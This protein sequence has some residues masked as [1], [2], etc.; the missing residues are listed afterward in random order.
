MKRIFTT[1]II[2]FVVVLA[3]GGIFLYSKDTW[4][5]NDTD[6]I[7]VA[8]AGKSDDKAQKNGITSAIEEA[9]KEVIKS[10]AK[11][12][13]DKAVEQ[14]AG[15]SSSEVREMI[16]SVAE[17]DKDR[18]TDIIVD[19]ITIEDIPDV[20]AYISNK[21][22]DGLKDYAKEKLTEEDYSELTGILE[23]YSDKAIEQINGVKNN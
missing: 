4:F 12:V 7:S 11:K 18:I 22:V 1:F 17:E 21:D 13:V 16:D 19:N 14:Y 20:E 5:K 23:K 15:E 9:K 3:I 6:E 8:A 10:V 2:T